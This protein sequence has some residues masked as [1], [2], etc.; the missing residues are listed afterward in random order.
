MGIL[1][2]KSRDSRAIFLRLYRLI[3]LKENPHFQRGG[4]GKNG[5]FSRLIEV[6]VFLK[7]SLKCT[8]IYI[9]GS[10]KRLFIKKID[11][12]LKISVKRQVLSVLY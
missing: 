9:V 4:S 10:G 7:E 3:R 11:F 2:L 6:K 1:L 12:M 5:I 8:K